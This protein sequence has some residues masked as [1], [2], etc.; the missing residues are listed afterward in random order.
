MHPFCFISKARFVRVSVQGGLHPSWACQPLLKLAVPSSVS[1]LV[2]GGLGELTLDMNSVDSE[3][4]FVG[5]KTDAQQS[6]GDQ[7]EGGDA[8]RR[9]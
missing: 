2:R 5:C 7:R 6:G 9:G 1:P 3:D 8:G 4:G